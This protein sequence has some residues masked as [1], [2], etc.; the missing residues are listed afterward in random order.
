MRRLLLFAFVAGVLVTWS[1]AAMAQRAQTPAAQLPVIGFLSTASPNARGSE[2]MA[3]FPSGLREAGFI[4]GQNVEIDY[5]WASDDYARLPDLS[6]DLVRRRVAVIV[7]AGGHVSALAAHEATKDIPIAFT[8]VTDPVQAGLVKS[9]NKP[10][11]NATGTAGLTSELDSKRLEYLHVTM[12]AAAVIGVLVNPNRPGLD[13]QLQE[14]RAAADKVNLKLVIRNAATEQHIDDAFEAFVS[15]RV[16]A[17][18]VTADPFSTIVVH[19]SC[20]SPHSTHSRRSI[21]G[22][23]S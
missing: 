15:Q 18:L 14:I 7:A 20:R 2:Q 9:L 16:N 12:P 3:A 5:R 13:G 4:E 1:P 6:A 21:N 19:K 8:T 22:A 17:L 23:S 10:G 11:G